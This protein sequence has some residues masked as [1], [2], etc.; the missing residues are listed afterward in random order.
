MAFDQQILANK[1]IRYRG[2]FKLSISELSES[3]G[4]DAEELEKFETGSKMPSGDEILIIADFY[5]CDYKFFI[6]NEKLAPFEQTD[7]LFRKYGDYFST[8]DRWAVQ[9][10]LFLAECESF[11]QNQLTPRGL[12]TFMFEKRGSYFKGHG[13]ECAKSLRKNMGYSFKEVPMDV[14]QDFRSIGIHVFRRKLENSNISGLYI[15]HPTAGNCILI[16]YSEDIYRQRFTAAHE[17]A[18]ALLDQEEDCVVSF[19]NWGKK[20]LVEIR[21]NKFASSYLIPPDFLK[22]IPQSREWDEKK[23]IDWANKFKVSVEALS[24]AL[25][26]CGLITEH[27]QSSLKQYKVSNEDKVDPELPTNLSA[28]EYARKL[29]LLEHGLSTS[30]VTR[31]FEAYHN[32]IISSA[33]MAEMLLTNEQNLSE[34]AQLYSQ[35]LRYGC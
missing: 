31:C 9:E 20:D 7:T 26:D 3:T 2:Q 34:I 27:V 22:S 35:E 32:N 25:L 6:S 11:L 18:H 14:Y 29:K 19:T 30:Y 12:N 24:Y 16:N 21:A 28:K 5:K 23:I 33:R 13:E 4:I 10:I 15:K 17:A 8:I 1:L